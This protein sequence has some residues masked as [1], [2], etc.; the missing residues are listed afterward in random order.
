MVAEAI[1]KHCTGE[2]KFV[3][4]AALAS[5]QVIE[6][7]DGRAAVVAGL[8]GFAAGDVAAA[9]T[10]GV[11]SIAK[12]AAVLLAGQEAWFL[13]ATNVASYYQ[14]GA[15]R[16]GIVVKD[17]ATGDTTVDVDLNAVKRYAID[18]RLGTWDSLTVAGSGATTLL[19]PGTVRLSLI[20][21]NEAEKCSYVSAESVD[22]DDK[23]IAEA[24]LTTVALA[25]S[26]TD[27]NVGLASADHA[28]DF[29]AITA[30]ISFHVLGGSNNIDVQLDDNVT[31]TAIVDTTLDKTDSTYFHVLIDARDKTSVKFYVNGARVLSSTTFD[32]SG[33]SSTLKA[34][35]HLEK[36]SSTN[37]ADVR[38]EQLRVW[39]QRA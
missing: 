8:A 4:A 36:T 30:F 5:G 13:P 15:I 35:A 27:F 24:V 18:S 3:T 9:Y 25:G 37:T 6:T 19:P 2:V 21:T 31:D 22:I 17:A 39:A 23:P 20:S 11:F 1:T 29:E 12:G 32:F 16:L 34:I 10:E 14:A 26:A 7:P 28:S 33:Y 38:V